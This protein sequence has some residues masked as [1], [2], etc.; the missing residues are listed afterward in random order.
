MGN[1]AHVTLLLVAWR[2]MRLLGRGHRAACEDEVVPV[3]ERILREQAEAAR[4]LRD[5]QACIDYAEANG[6]TP[7]QARAGA[8]L[9]ASDWLAEEVLALR[10]MARVGD[11]ERS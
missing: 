8:L 6:C 4:D 11:A 1:I 10:E 9:G 7:E 5:P 2:R 3:M